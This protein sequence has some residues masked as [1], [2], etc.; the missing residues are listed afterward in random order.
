[1][2]ISSRTGSRKANPSFDSYRKVS[3]RPVA[4]GSDSE[5]AQVGLGQARSDHSCLRVRNPSIEK[6]HPYAAARASGNE[7]Q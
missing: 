5:L 3:H 2:T 7:E 6:T 1:M 4:N